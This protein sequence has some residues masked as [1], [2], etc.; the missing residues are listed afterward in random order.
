MAAEGDR[1]GTS[2]GR[3]CLVIGNEGDADSGLVGQ[4]LVDDGFALLPVYREQFESWAALDRTAAPEMLSD[5]SL[6]LSLGSDWS[7][8][9]DHV[10][11][12]V[13]AEAEV[14]RAAH[15][16][17]VPILGIC[18]GAQMLAFALGGSVERAPITEIGWHKFETDIPGEVGPG[19]WPQWHSDRCILPAAATEFARSPA[20]PQGFRIGRSVG[21]QFHPEVTADIMGRW[22]AGPGEP[23]LAAVG[24]TRDQ[25]L[26][27]CAS[28]AERHATQLVPLMATLRAWQFDDMPA[29]PQPERVPS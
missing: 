17:G 4:H 27:Q 3:A 10:A 26:D 6:V 14:L 2:N 9:A 20:G 29:H 13:A 24:L 5:I 8:Y 22:A 28:N 12:P 11:G 7:V 1:V 21:L 18:F 19:P 15:D 23:E 25:L 16:A